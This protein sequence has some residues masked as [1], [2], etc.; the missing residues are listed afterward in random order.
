MSGDVQFG[1]RGGMV[2]DFI[3]YF[4]HAGNHHEYGNAGDHPV[5]LDAFSVVPVDRGQQGMDEICGAVLFHYGGLRP[6]QRYA[7]AWGV[8]VDA[9][10][11][12]ELPLLFQKTDDNYVGCMPDSVFR[13]YLHRDVFWRMGSD[14]VGCGILFGAKGGNAAESL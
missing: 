11:Y 2:F 10:P 8:G 9:A 12:A 5:L 4:Y 6:F 3:A 1:M 14:S 13:L 7:Q